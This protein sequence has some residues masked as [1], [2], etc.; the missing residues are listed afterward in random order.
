MNS[1]IEFFLKGKLVEQIF[2]NFW[3]NSLSHQIMRKQTPSKIATFHLTHHMV[4]NFD[5]SSTTDFCIIF[6]KLSIVLRIARPQITQNIFKGS[7]YN[8]WKKWT[9]QIYL[10]APKGPGNRYWKK[11]IKHYSDANLFIHPKGTKNGE[12]MFVCEVH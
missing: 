10:L 12:N 4:I 6:K 3:P 5:S 1:S 8:F 2:S 7:L 11:N 9:T